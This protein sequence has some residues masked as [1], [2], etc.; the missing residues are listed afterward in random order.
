MSAVGDARK[1]RQERL[2]KC[3]HMRAHH[4]QF[5]DGI[6]LPECRWAISLTD[7]CPCTKY[8]PAVLHP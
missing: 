6:D 3:G 1:R 4:A 2:C 8:E 5:P 7:P